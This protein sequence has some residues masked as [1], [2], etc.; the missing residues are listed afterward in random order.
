MEI[1]IKK[2][3]FQFIVLNSENKHKSLPKSSSSVRRYLVKLCNLMFLIKLQVITF[4]TIL[5]LLSGSSCSSKKK[6]KGGKE[7]PSGEIPAENIEPDKEISQL[8]AK[9]QPEPA[10]DERV[11][12]DE[13]ID[14]QGYLKQEE[15]FKHSTPSAVVDYLFVLDNSCS[16]GPLMEAVRQGFSALVNLVGVLPEDTKIATMATLHAQFDDLTKKGIGLK[17]YDGIENEPGFLDFYHKQARDDFIKLFPNSVQ[18]YPLVGCENKWF[19]PTETD[20]NE[21][22]CIRAAFQS[23]NSCTGTEAGILAF[24][25]LLEKNKGKSIFRESAIANVIFVSDTHDPGINVRNKTGKAIIEKHLSFTDLK[26]K[27]LEDNKLLGFKV[28]AIAPVNGKKCTSESYNDGSYNKLVEASQGKSVGCSQNI[29]YVE[30]M[31][32]MVT[33]SKVADIAR[34]I[35]KYQAVKILSIK[36]DGVAIEDYNFDKKTNAVLIPNIKPGANVKVD[37][38]Y[39]STSNLFDE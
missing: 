19:T 5:V 25:Q 8:D 20:E 23:Q 12:T 32:D 36:V 15:S 34:Y 17:G 9:S 29:D 37:I 24:Q 13:T 14:T 1:L 31:Q 21:D 30:F 27:V 28:H 3:L 38:H 39:E 2:G 26:K 6:F 10:I 16:S 33:E 35:L 22:L 4:S 18:K 11:V 7:L